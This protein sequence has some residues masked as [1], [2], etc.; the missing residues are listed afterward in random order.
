MS[1]CRVFSCVVGRG[2]LLW[3]VCSLGK[4][5]LAF[6][7]LHFCIS[8]P[9]LPATPGISWLPTFA[10]QSPMMKR[11]SFL[12]LVLEDLIGLHRTVQ[13]WLL[14]NW[15]ID[16]DYSDTEW[17]S[18]ETNRNLSVIF[19]TVPAYHILDSLV[20]Y[21]SHSIFTKEFL[22]TVVAVMVIWIKF[23]NKELKIIPLLPYLHQN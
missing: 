4:T 20:D 21:E 1:M 15:G 22:P 8:R 9:N 10:F 6:A 13:A 12:V 11:T 5:L 2:C 19:E 23:T 18:L 7:L 16:L 14:Q 3:S 17:F